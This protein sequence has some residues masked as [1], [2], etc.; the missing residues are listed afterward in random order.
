M[1]K[2]IAFLVLAAG[3]SNR[4]GVAIKQLLPWGKS[5]LL[6]HTLNE[7]SAVSE[8][9]YVILGAHV[10]TIREIIPKD[11][12]VVLNPDWQRGMGSSIA[13]GVSTIL[14][15]TPDVDGI[16]VLLADQ[17]LLD[18]RFY[19][20]LVKQYSGGDYKIVA[21]SYGEKL[22]VPAIFDSLLFARLKGLHE[23][24]GARNIIQE[25]FSEASAVDP[26]GMET[27]IDTVETYNQ[28]T[29]NK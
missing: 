17:P 22:G 2:K 16:L 27:D 4:M 25:Y 7:V 1:S 13:V 9:R 3:A 11:V 20:E 5:T 28:L 10:K 26:K 18:S 19:L 8:L 29:E 14:D 24:F 12:H 23:D 15:D 21:T 6:G